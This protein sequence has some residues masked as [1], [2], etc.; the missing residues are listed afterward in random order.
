M[1]GLAEKGLEAKAMSGRGEAREGEAES[2]LTKVSSGLC[3][4]RPGEL[5]GR[6]CSQ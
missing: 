1:K 5:D 6:Q 2:G 4:E 3:S